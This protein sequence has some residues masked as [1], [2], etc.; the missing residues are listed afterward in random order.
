MNANILKSAICRTNLIPRPNPTLFYFPGIN[1]CQ[2][3]WDNSKFE[4][5][6][7]SLQNNFDIILQEYKQLKS[8]KNTQNDYISGDHKLH[9]GEWQWYSCK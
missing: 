5:L 2:P 7:N 9:D 8:S 1:N 3:K 4:N 6:T